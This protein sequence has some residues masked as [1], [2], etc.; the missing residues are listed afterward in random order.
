[1]TMDKKEQAKYTG[2]AKFQIVLLILFGVIASW[3]LYKPS[4]GFNTE[5]DYPDLIP[6]TPQKIISFGGFPSHVDVGMYLREIPEADIIKGLFKADLTVWFKF[7]PSI[8]SL[9]KISQFSFENAKITYK[10]KPF[11]KIEGNNIIAYYD[12]TAEFSHSLNYKYFPFDDHRVSFALT[13]NALSPSEASF[14]SSK[15]NLRINEE[16][17]TPGL[18][19]VGKKIKTGYITDIFDPHD[20]KARHTRPRIIFSIDLAREGVRH[21]VTILLPLLLIFFI[22]LFTLSFNPYGHNASNII[23]ISIATVTAVIA[24]RFIVEN[25]SPKSGTFMIS[26]HLFILF[27]TAC[28]SIFIVNIFAKKIKGIYK[29]IIALALV[30]FVLITLTF[31]LTPMF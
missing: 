28:T 21:I 23:S 11:T 18:K 4:V 22:G 7:D 15:T 3:I 31:I 12:M 25:M 26:D 9:D 19:F 16:I 13:N 6:I 5:D 17:I 30:L 8:I 2:S 1:M 10:S 14:R 20:P 29:N 27:L 24:H